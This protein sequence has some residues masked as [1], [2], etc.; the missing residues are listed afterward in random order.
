MFVSGTNRIYP[1]FIQTA[2]IETQDIAINA[3]GGKE[4]VLAEV[5]SLQVKHSGFSTCGVIDHDALAVA[6]VSQS[7]Q[8]A[9]R[10]V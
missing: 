7:L 5:Y 8:A 10:A 1:R 2:L 9:D 6:Q 3:I 4:S